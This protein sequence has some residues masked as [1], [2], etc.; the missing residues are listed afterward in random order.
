MD[1]SNR[2]KPSLKFKPVLYVFNKKNSLKYTC[3]LFCLISIPLWLNTTIAF[4]V[5]QSFTTKN[6]SISYGSKLYEGV[7]E[8]A[9]GAAYTEYYNIALF[10]NLACEKIL[11]VPRLIKKMKYLNM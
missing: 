10:T 9:K 3:T 8:Y 6:N 5:K 2:V 7:R 1:L 11:M 4:L